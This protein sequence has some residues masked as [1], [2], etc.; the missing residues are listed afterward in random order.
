MFWAHFEGGM[1]SL[2]VV[3]IYPKM[4]CFIMWATYQELWN[5]KYADVYFDVFLD[6]LTLDS[7]TVKNCEKDGIKDVGVIKMMLLVWELQALWLSYKMKTEEYEKANN[8]KS[9]SPNKK[10]KWK[11]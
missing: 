4:Y 10:K 7:K 9:L 8:K 6:S 11:K 1:Y 5:L 3:V 2:I